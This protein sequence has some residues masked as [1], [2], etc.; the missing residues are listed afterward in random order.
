MNKTS[1]NPTAVPMC[2]WGGDGGNKDIPQK[3]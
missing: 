3:S 1:K 2:T